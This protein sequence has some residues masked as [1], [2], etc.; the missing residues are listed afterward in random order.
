MNPLSLFRC[1]LLSSL[2]PCRALAVC[3][4][5]PPTNPSF[6]RCSPPLFSKPRPC[7]VS[8]QEVPQ[9][10]GGHACSV[11]CHGP[12]TPHP[13]DFKFCFPLLGLVP[14]QELLEANRVRILHALPPLR[15]PP[16]GADFRPLSNDRG[17]LAKQ[18]EEEGHTAGAPPG[19]R[20]G[21]QAPETHPPPREEGAFP[22]LE[23]Q[24]GVKELGRENGGGKGAG[25]DSGAGIGAGV[26][27]GS[28]T[29][30]ESEGE[31]EGEEEEGEGGAQTY[32][33]EVVEGEIVMQA[34]KALPPYTMWIHIDK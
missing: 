5:P 15:G 23:E 27:G 28:G 14:P 12:P 8:P 13:K 4:Q 29:P 2:C 19:G 18:G 21:S 26:K 11:L 3:S 1:A 10:G 30:G 25:A 9:G 20:A 7:G 6:L 32:G 24:P 33:V 17:Q 22:E 16:L 31:S 34:A